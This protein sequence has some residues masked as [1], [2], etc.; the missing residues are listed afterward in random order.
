MRETFGGEFVVEAR[1]ILLAST[2]VARKALR[3]DFATVERTNTM[4]FAPAQFAQLKWLRIDLIVF[5][6]LKFLFWRHTEN[7]EA[8][9]IC[10]VVFLRI[11]CWLTLAPRLQF[12]SN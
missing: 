10:Y 7:V 1:Q 2:R 4:P 3:I 12:R 9:A 5:E 6:M 11:I 8:I